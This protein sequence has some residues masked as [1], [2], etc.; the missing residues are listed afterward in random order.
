MQPTDLVGS[1]VGVDG[2]LKKEVDAFLQGTGVQGT[3]KG[4]VNE[5]LI[6]RGKKRRDT[7]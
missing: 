5:R 7:K 6:C 4:Q 3:T 1:R 2:A